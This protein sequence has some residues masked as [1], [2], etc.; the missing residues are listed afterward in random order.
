MDRE[1]IER[2][3]ARILVPALLAFSSWLGYANVE[4]PSDTRQ[5]TN[6]VASLVEYHLDQQA[7]AVAAALDTREVK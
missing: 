7:E 4:R 6:M 1:Y 5:C 3:V 2:V